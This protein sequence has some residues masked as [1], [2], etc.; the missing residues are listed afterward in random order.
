MPVAVAV[1]MPVGSV[2]AFERALDER[3]YVLLRRH[4]A[5]AQHAREQ[6]G[7]FYADSRQLRV[8]CL[9]RAFRVPYC[10]HDERLRRPGRERSRRRVWRPGRRRSG[11]GR[12]R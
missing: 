8:G 4:N 7:A 9:V 11:L 12:G 2:L 1:A 3:T 6:P 5:G 10:E